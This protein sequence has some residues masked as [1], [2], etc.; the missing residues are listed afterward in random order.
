MARPSN[1]NQT[2]EEIADPEDF[3]KSAPRAIVEQD[4]TGALRLKETKAVLER[5]SKAQEEKFQAMDADF[6]KPGALDPKTD[7][8]FPKKVRGIYLGWQKGQGKLVQHALGQL[9]AKGRPI[10]LRFNGTATLTRELQRIPREDWGTEAAGMEIE[11][12]GQGPGSQGIDPST[13]EVIPKAGMKEFVVRMYE[14]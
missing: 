11:Y 2:R 7:K 14:A 8:A 9:D 4:L 10:A 1:A 13:G 6:W 5:L 3:I 12:L